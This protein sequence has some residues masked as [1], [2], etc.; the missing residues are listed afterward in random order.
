MYCRATRE[1]HCREP[2]IKAAFEDV[3]GGWFTLAEQL[4]GWTEGASSGTKQNGEF[5]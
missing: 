5:E 4:S 3:A 2:K 1:A